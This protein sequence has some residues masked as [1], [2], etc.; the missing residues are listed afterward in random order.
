MERAD[1]GQNVYSVAKCYHKDMPKGDTGIQK[2]DTPLSTCWCQKRL[3]FPEKLE[4]VVKSWSLNRKPG[5]KKEEKIFN[6]RYFSK[7]T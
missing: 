1:M 7:P 2:T 4:F 5:K 6:I 3:S